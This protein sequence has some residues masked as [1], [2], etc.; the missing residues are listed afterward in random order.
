[1]FV[2]LL[3]LLKSGRRCGCS[4]CLTKRREGLWSGDKIFSLGREIKPV[5]GVSLRLTIPAPI[6][7]MVRALHTY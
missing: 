3:D 6:R 2:L 1:M 7:I 5:S 4:V